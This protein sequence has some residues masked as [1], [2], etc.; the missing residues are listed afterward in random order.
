MDMADIMMTIRENT[1]TK[2]AADILTHITH[3]IILIK[4]HETGLPTHIT[5]ATSNNNNMDITIRIIANMMVPLGNTSGTLRAVEVLIS[6]AV[7]VPSTI[8]VPMAMV[9]PMVMVVVVPMATE[10]PIATGETPQQKMDM[11]AMD[12]VTTG[13]PNG[14]KSNMEI[15]ESC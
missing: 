5:M 2:E 12:T 7:G 8:G 13:T 3:T 15:V 4:Y 9:V 10:V 6:L 14:I 11:V 1:H